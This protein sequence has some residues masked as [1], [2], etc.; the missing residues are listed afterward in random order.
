MQDARQPQISQVRQL[1]FH[2]TRGQLQ[3]VGNLHQ[4][5]HRRALERDVELST[6]GC[7][8]GA[9]AVKGRDHAE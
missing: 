1:Q 7:E 5:R 6:Q 4:M 3:P 2:G 8:I 9:I